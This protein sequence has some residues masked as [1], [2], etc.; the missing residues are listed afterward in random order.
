MKNLKSS[1]AS[2]S[3]LVLLVALTT[4]VNAQ[5]TSAKLNLSFATSSMMYNT[6]KAKAATTSIM[7][8]DT[9]PNYP[10]IVSTNSSMFTTTQP[11]TKFK[12]VTVSLSKSKRASL[13]L[14]NTQVYKAASP[15][16]NKPFKFSALIFTLKF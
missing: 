16:T 6:A 11:E 8:M 7:L 9:Q 1:F 10:A 3:A 15:T 14:H 4:T 12:P 13:K 5:N 2:F